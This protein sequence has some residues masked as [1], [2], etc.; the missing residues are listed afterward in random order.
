MLNKGNSAMVG[1]LPVVFLNYAL[2]SI[3]FSI[4]KIALEVSP[5]L[6]LTGFR[7]VLA[8]LILLAFIA[9]KKRSLKISK[10]QLLPL[11]LFS[12]LAIYLTNACE[13]WGLQYL[14]AAKACLIYSLSPFL[15]ALLS[16]FQFKEK[17]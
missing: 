13:F 17:I 6:F 8:G 16:Y 9:L 12:L 5:P 7:M 2:W 15:A 14:S 11:C 1:Y 10:D 3:C 4:G